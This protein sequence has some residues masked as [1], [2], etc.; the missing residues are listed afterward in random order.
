MKNNVEQYIQAYK[1]LH[2]HMKWK[3]SDKRILMMIASIYVLNQK[4]LHVEQLLDLSDKIKQKASLFS[5][6]RSNSRFTTAAMLDVKFENPE[7]KIQELL[8]LYDLF[9][10]VKFGSGAFTYIAASILLTSEAENARETVSKAKAIYDGMKKEHAFLTSSNDYPLATLLA[11]ENQPGIIN[12]IERFYEDLSRNGFRKGN[13]L[14]FLSHILALGNDEGNN[15]LI[16][17]AIY[18][19]DSFQNT[20]FKVKSMYYPI[21]GML[22][23]LPH[24]EY[25]VDQIVS[26]YEVLKQQ[27]DFKWQ[28]DM[29][30]I[31]AAC[32]LVNEK[33]GN[34]QLAEA[35]LSTI[36][37]AILQAQQAVMIATMA[38][39]SASSSNSG[40]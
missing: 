36:L 16:N 11:I 4:T 20:P 30:V 23:L 1:E 39:A 7:E 6:L 38:A 13:D 26:M 18:I 14:Q 5:S 34:T 29:N 25:S 19:K 31:I 17:R 10:E 2:H 9:R 28:K 27:K 3:V 32:I 15:V 33:I 8:D 37:E 21:I 22:S 24:D 40:N 35:S 12:H